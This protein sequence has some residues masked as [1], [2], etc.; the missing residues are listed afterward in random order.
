MIKIIKK[1]SIILA[2]RAK[3]IMKP[4]EVGKL[5]GKRVAWVNFA[6]NCASMKRP[7]E[8]VQHFFLTE[9]GTEGSMA[10]DGEQLSKK[11]I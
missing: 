1:I 5:G 3:F 9:L 4:P 8:H 11:I 10:G 2:E 6:Q 7:P